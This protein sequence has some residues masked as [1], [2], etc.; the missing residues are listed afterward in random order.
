M[1]ADSSS[2]PKGVPYIQSGDFQLL[3][4]DEVAARSA[5]LPQAF[6][7]GDHDAWLNTI[8]P[9]ERNRILAILNDNTGNK[10][11]QLR[12]ALLHAD[13]VKMQ[14]SD[15]RWPATLWGD[16]PAFKGFLT[17]VTDQQ[18]L[19]KRASEQ[20]WKE[21]LHS[22]TGGLLHDFGNTMS[23]IFSLAEIYHRQLDDSNSMKDGIN[24]VKEN[25]YQAYG[26]IRRILSLYRDVP[27]ERCSQYLG[28]TLAEQAEL[29]RAILPKN[30]QIA[31]D[32]NSCPHPVEIDEVGFRQCI[33][34]LVVNARD[35][36]TNHG[37]ITVSMRYPITHEKHTDT[38]F[39]NPPDW[40]QDYVELEVHDNG[41][42]I[43]LELQKQIF[44][45]YFSTKAVNMGS[46][47]G[48]YNIKRFVDEHQGTVG[49]K[50]M[51]GE[52]SSFYILLP[53]CVAKPTTGSMLPEV[54]DRNP[55]TMPE[56]EPLSLFICRIGMPEDER[57]EQTLREHH[58]MLR[59]TTGFDELEKLLQSATRNPDVIF[60]CMDSYRPEHFARMQRLRLNYPDVKIAM[61]VICHPEDELPHNL[62]ETLD[63]VLP[64]T[65]S[66]SMVSK[67]LIQLVKPL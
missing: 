54:L 67:R 28:I 30:I 24:Q 34:N 16:K 50:S 49:V 33:I 9:A 10:P 43:S 15:L 65:E 32:I 14:I 11:M 58:W 6:I 18:A 19:I 26:I 61:Q 38:T 31:F 39:I 17:N 52:G 56:P 57:M 60:F 21:T 8:D 42:G 5:G 22:I 46:G 47:L 1:I 64:R 25:A 59:S 29:L 55:F 23:G 37:V 62:D 3:W 45:P 36:I 35:A 12:Y 48:L 40:N 51:P 4:I 53:V 2:A 44:Q 27:G 7:D 63:V 41:V 13:G 66:M 20:N